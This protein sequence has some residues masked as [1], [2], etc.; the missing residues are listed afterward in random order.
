M[1]KRIDGIVNATLRS[2]I[3][4]DGKPASNPKLAMRLWV[5]KKLSATPANMA[6]AMEVRDET[7]K[8]YG[9]DLSKFMDTSVTF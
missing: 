4:I 1:S 3:K 5:F 8:E 6:Y 7:L 9:I 2:E